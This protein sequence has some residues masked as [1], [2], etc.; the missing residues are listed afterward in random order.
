MPYKYHFNDCDYDRIHCLGGFDNR[1]A[2]NAIVREG[3]YVRKETDKTIKKLE[4][5]WTQKDIREYFK[6]RTCK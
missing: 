4:D 2:V 1:K 5:G 3:L 6:I